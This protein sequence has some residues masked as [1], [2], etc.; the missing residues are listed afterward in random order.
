MRL[1]AIRLFQRVLRVRITAQ[2]APPPEGFDL[3]LDEDE[4]VLDAD[5][6][7]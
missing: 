4:I 3:W 5:N 7:G 6:I 1:I 2:W